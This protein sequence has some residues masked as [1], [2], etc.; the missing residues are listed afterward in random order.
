MFC[1]LSVFFSVKCKLELLETRDKRKVMCFKYMIVNFMDRMS[2]NFATHTS[3]DR[4]CQ[5]LSCQIKNLWARR[6]CSLEEST[7]TKGFFNYIDRSWSK[8]ELSA[9]SLLGCPLRNCGAL[10]QKIIRDLNSTRIVCFYPSFTFVY[11]FFKRNF[12]DFY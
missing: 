5:I 7:E 12:P 10:S 3:Y 9:Q 8:E 4:Y 2:L 6:K 1:N 11:D